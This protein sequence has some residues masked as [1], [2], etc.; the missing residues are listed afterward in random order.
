MKMRVFNTLDN[1]GTTHL[2]PGKKMP[3]PREHPRKFLQHCKMDLEHF[4]LAQQFTIIVVNCI[5]FVQSRNQITLPPNPEMLL[6]DLTEQIFEIQFL[7]TGNFSRAGLLSNNNDRGTPQANYLVR[8][9]SS[10]CNSF[11]R[12]FV[13]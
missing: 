9:D 5:Y 1:S 2:H 8:C 12:S 10:N 11:S 7:L 13:M 6:I 4:T 3:T